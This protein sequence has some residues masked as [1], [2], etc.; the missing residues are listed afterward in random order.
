MIDTIEMFWGGTISCCNHAGVESFSYVPE[1]F[2][3]LGRKSFYI[4]Y[5]S[6]FQGLV[7]KIQGLKY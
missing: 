3:L 2:F 5:K 1:K 7:F 6:I 4:R